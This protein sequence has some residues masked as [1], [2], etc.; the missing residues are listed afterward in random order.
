MSGS[1][2][3]ATVRDAVRSGSVKRVAQA[4]RAAVLFVSRAF[5]SSLR[6]MLAP[7]VFRTQ[8]PVAQTPPEPS[9][10]PAETLSEEEA[11]ALTQSETE[12]VVEQPVAPPTMRPALSPALSAEVREAACARSVG[13][14]S[15]DTN[16]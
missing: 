16:N 4:V 1:R 2:V 9:E 14:P 15:N 10:L 12:P 11:L 6:L 13:E 7:R 8:A 3:N 5:G